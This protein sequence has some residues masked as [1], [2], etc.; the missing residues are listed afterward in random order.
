[1]QW[2]EHGGRLNAEG[3]EAKLAAGE[4][5]SESGRSL[6]VVETE[7]VAGATRAVKGSMLRFDE[8]REC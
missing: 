4:G 2:I 7:A 5:L 6:H 8:L 1:M 3:L